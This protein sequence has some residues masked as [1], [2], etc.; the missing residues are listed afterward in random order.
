MLQYFMSAEILRYPEGDKDIKETDELKSN[1]KRKVF[2]FVFRLAYV[3]SSQF[4]YFLKTTLPPQFKTPFQL[5]V[6][7]HLSTICKY[8]YGSDIW[9]THNTHWIFLIV[10]QHKLKNRTCPEKNKKTFFFLHHLSKRKMMTHLK[11]WTKGLIKSVWRLRKISGSSLQG[12]I[13]PVLQCT[14]IFLSVLCFLWDKEQCNFSP[15]HAEGSSSIPRMV[16]FRHTMR[17]HIVLIWF[18]LV[19]FFF[20]FSSHSFILSKSISIHYSFREEFTIH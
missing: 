9:T 13:I 11:K 12:W 10:A 4:M 2:C 18:I 1:R 15:I 6:S 3:I 5:G 16:S 8:R 7:V 20:F 17:F 19:F 14:V